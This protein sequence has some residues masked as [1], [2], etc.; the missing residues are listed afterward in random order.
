MATNVKTLSPTTG[1]T[2][3][4]K[5]LDGFLV[6]LRRGFNFSAGNTSEWSFEDWEAAVD[7]VDDDEDCGV[8]PKVG[9]CLIRRSTAQRAQ[10][11]DLLMGKEAASH[12]AL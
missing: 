12:R 1:A 5:D 10:Q 8:A 11:V 9:E 3:P 7:A 4:T 2:R 6:I